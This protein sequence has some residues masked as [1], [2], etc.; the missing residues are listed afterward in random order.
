MGD[1]DADSIEKELEN[2][3][4]EL[5]YTKPSVFGLLPFQILRGTKDACFGIPKLPSHICAIVQEH[6]RTK[7]E[8]EQTIKDEEDEIERK[9]TEKRE[10]RATASEK[11]STKPIRRKRG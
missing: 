5:G 9:E 2:E 3:L 1:V 7:A 10:K 8:E 4:N 11:I 6:R